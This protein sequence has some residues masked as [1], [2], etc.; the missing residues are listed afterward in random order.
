MAS[1][2]NLTILVIDNG[3]FVETACRL[4]KDVKQCYYYTPWEDSFPKM[5]RAY[6]GYG[7]EGIERVDSP[8]GKCLDEADLVVF[9]DIYFGALQSRLESMGKKCFG[10]GYGEVLE[11]SRDGTKE[12]MKSLGLPVAK[13]WKVTGVKALRDLL[14]EHKDVFVKINKFRGMFET[15]YSKNYKISEPQ[16]DEIEHK[17]GAFKYITEFIVEENLKDCVE[18]GCDFYTVGG[19]FPNT[20]LAGMEIKDKAYLGVVRNAK[21]FPEWLTHFND[22][23]SPTLDALDYKGLMS[24]EIRVGKD[25]KGYMIDLCA[26]QASPPGELYQEMYT[27]FTD[28]VWNVANGKI[29]EPAVQAKY[30]A[31]ALIHSPWADHNWQPISFPKE[32]REYVKLRNGCKINGQYYVIPQDTGL[33][34]VGAVWGFGDTKEEAIDM[35]KEIAKSVDG[36]FVEVKTEAF[37]NVEEELEKHADLGLAWM[38]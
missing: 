27:N 12:L 31:E 15:F 30:G 13:W 1:V 4:A 2:D 11:T 6:I 26:R 22:T 38:D 21:D 37:D 25:K 8:F 35:V 14:K 20:F 28:I 18:V 34:E 32:Y 19:K 5:N 9:P 23:I 17:L 10:A 33:P 3:L 36:F 7:L 24:T 16:L 29:I